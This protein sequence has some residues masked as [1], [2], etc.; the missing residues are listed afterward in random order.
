MIKDIIKG[1]L[2]SPLNA[3]FIL[4]ASIHIV[5]ESI[6]K[7]YINI[8]NDLTSAPRVIKRKIQIKLRKKK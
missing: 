1:I 3:L 5:I 8:K 2:F 6:I 4:I 7:R